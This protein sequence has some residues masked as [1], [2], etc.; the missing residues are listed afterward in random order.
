[1][2]EIAGRMAPL[3]GAFHVPLESFSTACLV[4]IVFSI[5]IVLKILV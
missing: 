5:L 4:L 2:S 3:I 1:M